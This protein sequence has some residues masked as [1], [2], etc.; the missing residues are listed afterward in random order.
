MLNFIYTGKAPNLEKMVA[1]LLA[2][3]DKVSNT[4]FA[5]QYL[6]CVLYRCMI[7]CLSLWFVVYDE[8]YLKLKDASTHGI[9]F[10][11]QNHKFYWLT[12][13]DFL[14]LL[15]PQYY[16]RNDKDGIK[17]GYQVSDFT[18]REKQI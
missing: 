6:S 2:A 3:A 16:Q 17:I 4:N 14:F 8:P 12:I 11:S 9:R 15:H 18:N 10:R 5:S 7:C 13:K 1:D